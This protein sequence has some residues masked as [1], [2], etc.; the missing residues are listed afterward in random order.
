MISTTP[1]AMVVSA[2]HINGEML[3]V[4]QNRFSS[5]PTTYPKT[6]AGDASINISKLD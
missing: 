5:L 3:R 1:H 4:A 6:V 2:I